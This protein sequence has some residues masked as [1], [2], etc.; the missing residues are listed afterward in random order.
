MSE[1]LA[2]AVLPDGIDVDEHSAYFGITDSSTLIERLAE[3][4]RL[5]GLGEFLSITG[6]LLLRQGTFDFE[7]AAT[8]LEVEGGE[9]YY[10]LSGP[11]GLLSL[12]DPIRL[13]LGQEDSSG[14]QGG[15]APDLAA[16]EKE[17]LDAFNDPFR[18]LKMFAIGHVVGGLQELDQYLANFEAW[19][20]DVSANKVRFLALHMQIGSVLKAT[21][22]GGEASSLSSLTGGPVVRA[23]VKAPEGS[24][25]AEAQPDPEP[26]P[27]PEPVSEPVI[28]PEPEPEPEPVPEPV[29]EPEPQPVPEPV[30][31]PEPEPQP[32]P[33][34]V[35]E[36]EPEPQPVPEPII[37]PEPAP[38]VVAA[39][40]PEPA[41]EVSLAAAFEAPLTSEEKREAFDAMDTNKDGV[42]SP[43]EFVAAPEVAKLPAPIQQELFEAIDTNKN[44]VLEFEEFSKAAENERAVPILA[45]KRAPLGATPQPVPQQAPTQAAQPVVQPAVQPAAQPMVQP[46]VQ[47]AAQPMVQPAVQ[48]AV[49]PQAA[50]PRRIRGANVR[51]VHHVLQTGI[52][53]G[54][55]NI[56]VEHHWRTCPVC[57]SRL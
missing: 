42:I 6:D 33:E 57:G 48:P 24:Q 39:P 41:P 50:T 38:A 15:A 17:A 55:C 29:I 9:I 53:C 44:Q 47:P 27:E 13:Y 45:P 5:N 46:A 11:F 20:K 51:G 28:E 26:E 2:G 43:A 54:A 19:M 1:E 21:Q 18:L 52:F 56:G 4:D 7:S 32:V 30:I 3:T 10:L 34:P 31:E 37:E 16:S 25:T 8:R 23:E 12:T 49:Q 35:I 36:P 40:Q 14:N 22:S